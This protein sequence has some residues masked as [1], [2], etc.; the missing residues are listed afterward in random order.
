MDSIKGQTFFITG[1]SG[2]IGSNLSERLINEGARVIVYDNL[3]T[4]SKA[5]VA[6]T[7]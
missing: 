6:R 5:P 3:N 4:G 1:G 7:A 2:F